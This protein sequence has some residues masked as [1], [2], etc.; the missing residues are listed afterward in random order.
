MLEIS[1]A[2][3]LEAENFSSTEFGYALDAYLTE[4]R[5][6]T[7][8][9]QQNITIVDKKILDTQVV[10]HEQFSELK[11]FEIALAN[12]QQE[13]KDAENAEEIKAIDEI[14]IIRYA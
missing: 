12:R 11:K 8:K 2:M 14:N 9:L 6:A 3:K 5:D 1:E 4:A 10:L 13:A 7:S